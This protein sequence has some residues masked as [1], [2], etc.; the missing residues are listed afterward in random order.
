MVAGARPD[1]G[2]YCLYAHDAGCDV[3]A[4]PHLQLVSSCRVGMAGGV[5]DQSRCG[6]H[7]FPAD[8]P[9]VSERG[10]R[11]EQIAGPI[12]IYA[13]NFRRDLCSHWTCIIPLPGTSFRF[14]ALVIDS[15]HSP[16]R[17]WLVAFR[18]SLANDACTPK[19][20]RHGS[21]G[22][23]CQYSCILPAPSGSDSAF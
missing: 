16:S 6:C 13:P 22:S 17:R 7:C 2:Y 21:G 12:L 4:S 23:V 18:C 19:D 8:G 11:G 20:A 10:T 1:S 9:W 14:L 15:T 5:P 3:I